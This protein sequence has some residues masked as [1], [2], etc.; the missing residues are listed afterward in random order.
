MRVDTI[1]EEDVLLLEKF[2][3]Q[4]RL[5]QPFRLRLGPPGC[6]Q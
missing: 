1:L 5:S 6:V 3:A 2:E 4:E